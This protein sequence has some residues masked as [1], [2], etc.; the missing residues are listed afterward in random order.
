MALGIQTASGVHFSQLII[1]G[2]ESQVRTINEGQFEQ[3]GKLTQFGRQRAPGG[4]PDSDVPDRTLEIFPRFAAVLVVQPVSQEHA[5]GIHQ[6]LV[7]FQGPVAADDE[8]LYRRF[9]QLVHAAL[10]RIKS[11]ECLA[12][13][14]ARKTKQPEDR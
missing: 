2:L 1:D 6:A 4:L 14:S 11:E 10:Q 9:P 12:G 7:F 3:F 13:G 8:V 5:Q